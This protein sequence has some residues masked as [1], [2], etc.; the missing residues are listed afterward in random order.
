VLTQ[1]GVKARGGAGRGEIASQISVS[2]S[3]KYP[4]IDEVSL[5]NDAVVNGGL[6]VSEGAHGQLEMRSSGNAAEPSQQVCDKHEV[7]TSLVEP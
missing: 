5:E 7:R 4:I 3:R 2:F 6:E 1:L